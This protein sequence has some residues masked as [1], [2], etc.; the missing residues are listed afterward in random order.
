[1]DGPAEG[2]PPQLGQVLFSLKPGEPTMVETVDGYIVGVLAEI[3]EADPKTDPAGYAQLRTAVGRSIA[4]D[5]ST[6]FGHALR[7]GAQPRINQA[8]LD[9]VTGRQQ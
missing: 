6:T 8:V 9:G 3:L 1:R 7:V 4:T 2:M 5:L